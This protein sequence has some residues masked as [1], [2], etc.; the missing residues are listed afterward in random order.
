MAD[1]ARSLEIKRS[2]KFWMRWRVRLGYPVAI[3]FLVLA[4][5]IPRSI[6]A[7]GAVAVL[8]LL[9]RAAAAGHLRKDEQL[10]T[11][12]PYAVTRN[13]L[14]F[15]SAILAAGFIVAGYSWWAGLIVAAYFA[16][17]YTAVI[18]NEEA[19]LRKRFGA[20]FDEYAARV[21]IFLP[22]FAARS[23]AKARFSWI[24]YRRNREYQALL[25]SLGGLAVLWLRMWVRTRWGY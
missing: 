19:D 18:R 4:R 10:A 16:V 23:G 12:G 17:F 15:G 25:G 13:P 8:G 6:L 11:T 1:D 5:P 20:A 22:W 14:Y 7:G 24:Q 9:I 3:V 2:R 21:P